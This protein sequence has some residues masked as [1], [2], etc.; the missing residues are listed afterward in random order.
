MVSAVLTLMQPYFLLDVEAP[1]P[2]AL[3]SVGF[4]GWVY[5]TATIGSLAALFA[6]LENI[7]KIVIK[8]LFF[9][10]IKAFF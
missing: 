3:L 10:L 8:N 5:Y 2:E 7:K 1:I 6:R 4:G 9:F